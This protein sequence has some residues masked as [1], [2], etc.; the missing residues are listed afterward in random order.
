MI[1]IKSIASY[2]PKKVVDNIHRAESF[3]E[4]EDFIRNKIGAIKL[5][6]KDEAQETSDLALNAVRTLFAKSPELNPAKLDALVVV[7]QNPDGE[8]LPHTSAILQHKLGLT[9]GVA[10][11]DISLGCSGYVYGLF[12]LKGFL[13]ASGLSNGV[14][15]T[16]DPYSKIID[17]ADRVTS[18]LFGDAATATWLGENPVWKLDS[19]GY[20]TNGSG[21]EYLCK[22]QKRLHMNGRQIFN[23]ANMQVAPHIRNL[24]DK[25]GLDERDI[26]LYC[27]HQGSAAIVNAIGSQFPAVFDR[28]VVDMLETGNT[29]S[30]SIPLL[31]ETRAFDDNVKRILLSGFG[32]GLSWASAIISKNSDKG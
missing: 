11:F 29:V 7:T 6:L 24:L 15:V 5:P 20:G 28:F 32:V 4:S 13:E 9:T 8:G 22:R 21:A 17:P 2:V 3:G 23:F 16:A 14:L 26:D 1:G 30:S 19:V 31:L 18:L 10:A 27:M 12:V 25:Q